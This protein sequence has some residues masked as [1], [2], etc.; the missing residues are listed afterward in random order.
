MNSWQAFTIDLAVL[1]S[2]T[3][4]AAMGRISTEVVIAVVATIAGARATHRSIGPKDPPASGGGTAALVGGGGAVS[5]VML[6]LLPFAR[7]VAA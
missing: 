3:V 6:G 5:A 4:L 7:R 2:V 1:T